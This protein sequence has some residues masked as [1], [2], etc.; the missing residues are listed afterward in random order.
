M[1]WLVFC[2]IVLWFECSL[3]ITAAAVL[4]A[5]GGCENAKPRWSRKLIRDLVPESRNCW[6]GK[7]PRMYV[8]LPDLAK[9]KQLHETR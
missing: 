7:P 3:L 9:H 1:L 8:S 6:R 5:N 2:F 4:K